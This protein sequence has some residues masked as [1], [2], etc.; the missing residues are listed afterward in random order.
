MFVYIAILLLMCF[1]MLKYDFNRKESVIVNQHEIRW[2]YFII[3]VL[4]LLAGLRNRVGGD[5]INYERHFDEYPNLWE[6]FC[7]NYRLEEMTQPIWFMINVILKTIW[8]KFLIVQLFHAIIIN[9]LFYLFIRR[10]T[11]KVFTAITVMYCI[12]W[13]NFNFEVLRESLCIALYLN[14]LLRL[15]EKKLGMYLIWCLPALGIH[16]FSFVMI[17]LTIVFYYL[18]N[19]V[20][21]FS[22]LLAVFVFWSIDLNRLSDFMLKMSIVFGDVNEGLMESYIF[23]EIY[24]TTSLNIFGIMLFLITLSLPVIVA[25]KYK[26]HPFITRMLWLFVVIAVFQSKY[27]IVSRFANYLWPLLIIVIINY[28]HTSRFKEI[29]SLIVGCLLIYNVIS[30]S[31]SF[32]KPSS[33]LETTQMYNCRYIPYKSVFQDPDPVRETYYGQ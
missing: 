13:W 25:I 30:Y 9:C 32:Y 16:Y 1:L 24:G 15:N 27:P 8:D 3:I 11:K 7:S 4:I 21:I 20:A 23:G 5:T 2:Q 19:K 12:L 31:L 22:A 18:N 14:G 33:E 29:Y 26:G 17:G 28:L 10:T 6:L